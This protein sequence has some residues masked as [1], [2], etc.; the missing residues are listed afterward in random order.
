MIKS[1]TIVLE[2]LR[3]LKIPDPHPHPDPFEESL[4]D[5]V[6]TLFCYDEDCVTDGRSLEEP[7]PEE[8]TR[9]SIERLQIRQAIPELDKEI[10]PATTKG[11]SGSTCN[12]PADSFLRSCQEKPIIL[13]DEDDKF[14]EEKSISKQRERCSVEKY[15][16]QGRNG[17]RIRE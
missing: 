8:Q 9:G 2:S 13:D 10:G 17:R 1:N 14:K 16:T 15:K 12:L 7:T 4:G 3:C 11:L 6:F 5:P